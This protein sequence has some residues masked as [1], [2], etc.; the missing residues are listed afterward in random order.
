MPNLRLARWVFNFPFPI[1]LRLKP[2][3]CP[4][5]NRRNI[6][7][8]PRKLLQ[9]SRLH[10]RTTASASSSIRGATLGGNALDSW[11]ETA[12]GLHSPLRATSGP[13]FPANYHNEYINPPLSSIHR[14]QRNRGRHLKTARHTPRLGGFCSSTLRR[15]LC[16]DTPAAASSTTIN[17]PVAAN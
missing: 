5:S 17:V 13:F 7:L 10:A 6:R 15:F 4:P 1:K 12:D 3:T 9:L 11:R 8:L 14:A 2:S 16:S